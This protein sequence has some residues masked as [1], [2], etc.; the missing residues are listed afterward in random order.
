MFVNLNMPIERKLAAI[1]FTDI[2]GSTA[3]MSKDEAVASLLNKQESIL[4]PLILEH[5]GTYVKSTTLFS[6]NL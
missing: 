6:A 5:N 2:V 1:M 3:Q 4:R